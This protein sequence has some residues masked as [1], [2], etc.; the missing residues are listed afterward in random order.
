MADRA[1]AAVGV[2]ESAAM[3]EGD[4]EG[5]EG[6]GADARD[7]QGGGGGGGG[8]GRSGASPLVYLTPA[9]PPR[10]LPLFM[11]AAASASAAATS[12]SATSSASS[13]SSSHFTSSSA[14]GKAAAPAPVPA[15]ALALA[16][17]PRR[18]R[19]LRAALAPLRRLALSF[20][21]HVAFAAFARS[22]PLWRAFLR[23]RMLCDLQAA[24]VPTHASFA[25]LRR[26]GRG[27]YG[28]VFAARKL[29]TGR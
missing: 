27:G 10:L 16:L 6:E 9:A 13:S 26:V 19:A 15:P 2:R 22:Q 14:L 23:I 3:D 20:A 28:S 11:L 25:W 4:E 17:A 7:V 24:T 29:D 1:G 21:A 8:G 12:S 18:L 5:D